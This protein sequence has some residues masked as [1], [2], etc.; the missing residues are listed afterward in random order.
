MFQLA[1]HEEK[2]AILEQSLTTTQEQLSQRV[3]EIVRLEQTQRKL[4]TE[5]KTVKE[6][7]SSYEDEIA[8]QKDAIGLSLASSLISS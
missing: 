8:S 5:L 2:L 3:G 1:H 7:A 4:S 6:R